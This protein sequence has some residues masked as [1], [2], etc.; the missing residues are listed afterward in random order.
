MQKGKG[1][2]IEGCLI[3]KFLVK[4][5]TY[6]F[7]DEFGTLLGSGSFGKVYEAIEISSGRCVAIK[8]VDIEIQHNREIADIEEQNLTKLKGSSPYLVNV[9]KY[10]EDVCVFDY[11][12]YFIFD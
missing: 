10:F 3:M 5:Y 6:L 1:K 8:E 4:V 9:I 12:F 2:T 7:S 11:L